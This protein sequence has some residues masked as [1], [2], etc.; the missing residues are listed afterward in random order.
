MVVV[1]VVV[2][3]MTSLDRVEGWGGICRKERGKGRKRKRMM[4]QSYIFQALI[5]LTATRT[6]TGRSILRSKQGST[7]STT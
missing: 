1:V 3:A 4:G 6:M 2:A 7:A 5:S